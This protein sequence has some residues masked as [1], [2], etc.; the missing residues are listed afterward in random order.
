MS[1]LFDDHPGSPHRIPPSG[2]RGGNG[3]GSL[4]FDPTDGH[5]GDLAAGYALGALEANER[6]WVEHHMRVCPACARLVATQRRTV[7]LLAYAVPPA[8]PE[9]DLK[10][11][12]LARIA[13]AA[14]AAADTPTP[15]IPASRPGGVAAI[16]ALVPGAGASGHGHR[17]TGWA[18]ALL[19][20]P[21][22]AALVVLGTWAFHLRA[23]ADE[24]GDRAESFGAILEQ[25]LAGGATVYRL[26]PGPAAPEAKGWVVTDAG[27]RS[28]TFYMKGDKAR[29]GER[30]RLFAS[31]DGKR[32]ALGTVK[33]DGQ[34]RGAV[35][36]SLDRPLSGYREIIVKKL[37]PSEANAVNP[38]L[39]GHV[40]TPSGAQADR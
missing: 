39:W 1:D 29:S 21:L 14:R 4:G 20:A 25:A 22:L 2:G 28:A 13:Q 11:T 38:A 19:T 24:R 30:Y 37:L 9:A 12:L 40:A 5:V 3:A 15:T 33:L 16:P 10:P 36:L 35:T 26:S 17:W 32:V 27:Q 6:A 23:E 8:V 7:A 18:T 31:A 34:G